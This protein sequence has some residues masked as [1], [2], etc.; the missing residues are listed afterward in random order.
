MAPGHVP[1]EHIRR[2]ARSADGG[3]A[4]CLRRDADNVFVTLTARGLNEK[5]TVIA[6]AENEERV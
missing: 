5:L 2:A 6:R 4:S 3:L 1:N